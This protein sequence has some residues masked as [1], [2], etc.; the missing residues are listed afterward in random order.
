MESLEG[1]EKQRRL[2]LDAFDRRDHEDRAVEHA[3]DA[4]DL[5][6]EVGVAGRVDQ[7]D[8]EVADSGT[9]RP[10]SGW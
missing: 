2:R 9:R 3:E 1:T 7:V 4:F 5:R 10:Q 8:G 6:D